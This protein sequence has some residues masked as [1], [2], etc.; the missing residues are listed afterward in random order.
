MF[1]RWPTLEDVTTFEGP[2]NLIILEDFKNCLPKSVATFVGGHKHPK[3]SSAAVLA[4]EYVLA[5]KG[6]ISCPIMFQSSS[7]FQRSLSVVKD[8]VCN[9]QK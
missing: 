9:G 7:S 2:R 6:A 3:P 1:D 5:H 4:D 8:T